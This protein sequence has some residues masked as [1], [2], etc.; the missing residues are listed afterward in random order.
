[1]EAAGL[2]FD[3]CYEFEIVGEHG[4]RRGAESHDS[5]LIQHP[6]GSARA[7]QAVLRNEAAAGSGKSAGGAVRREGGRAGRERGKGTCSNG[8]EAA[9]LD[10]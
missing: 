6:A 4:S 8:N 9:G 7:Q 3:E 1:M 5:I 2:T 10:L